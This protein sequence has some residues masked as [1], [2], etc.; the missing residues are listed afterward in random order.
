MIYR[1]TGDLGAVQHLLDHTRIESTILYLG[2]DVD[3]ALATAEQVEIC[4]LTVGC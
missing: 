3:D 1:R 4:S 2:I